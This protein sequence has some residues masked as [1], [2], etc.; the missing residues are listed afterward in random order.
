MII[1]PCTWETLSSLSSTPDNS[2]SNSTSTDLIIKAANASIQSKQKLLLCV[3]AGD[4]HDDGHVYGHAKPLSSI[5]LEHMKTLSDA[6]VLIYPGV[7]GGLE[8]FKLV[9]D[10]DGGLKSVKELVEV[11]VEQ[12]LSCLGLG[13]EGRVHRSLD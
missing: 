8:G 7:G 2:N 10:G 6:G 11:S 9:S 4:G 3:V 5:Q 13:L 12:L 1:L